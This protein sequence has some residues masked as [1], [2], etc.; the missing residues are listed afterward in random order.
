[1]EQKK[2]SW[3]WVGMA[4]FVLCVWDQSQAVERLGYVGLSY[5]LP[6]NIHPENSLGA[7]HE[8]I[9]TGYFLSEQWA[10]QMSWAF[11][12]NQQKRVTVSFGPEFYLMNDVTLTPF[13]YARFIY[14]VLP[15]NT[16]GLSTGFGFEYNLGAIAVENL[17]LRASLG[18]RQEFPDSGGRQTRFDVVQVGVTW[19]F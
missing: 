13:V 16:L 1:M 17:S 4:L 18:L 5:Y 8:Q 14:G 2:R 9:D 7:H 6:I 19:S 12:L 3:I 10:V 11:A 15:Q